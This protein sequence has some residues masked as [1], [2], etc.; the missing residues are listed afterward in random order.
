[1]GNQPYEGMPLP[2]Y[3][4]GMGGSITVAPKGEGT[5]RFT[6]CGGGFPAPMGSATIRFQARQERL[7]SFLSGFCRF[8]RMPLLETDSWQP[9][10]LSFPEVLT[11]QV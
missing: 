2:V 11:N 8:S 6:G 7:P 1:M 10:R 9:H 4:A 5:R 3:G